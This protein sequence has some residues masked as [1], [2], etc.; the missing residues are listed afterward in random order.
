MK[1]WYCAPCA[2]EVRE[3]RCPHCGKLE[4]ERAIVTP[5]RPDF[6]PDAEERN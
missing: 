4:Q 5:R 6:M 2:V 3:R 1:S